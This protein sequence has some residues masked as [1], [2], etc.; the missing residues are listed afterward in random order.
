[1]QRA[2]G[3][4][5]EQRVGA[6]GGGAWGAASGRWVPADRGEPAD[7][8]GAVP[9]GERRGE[10]GGDA[11]GAGGTVGVAGGS[12]GGDGGRR[13]GGVGRGVWA[14]EGGRGAR[15]GRSGV[16]DIHVGIYGKAE[17]GDDR[18]PRSGQHDRR[19]QRA[20]WGGE[21]GCSVRAVVVELRP[22]GVRH[23]W[24]AGRRREAGGSG[25]RRGEGPAGVVD[26]DQGRRG[27]GVEQRAGVD[28]NAVGV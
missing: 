14:G 21:R 16:R 6:G 17:G 11:G 22:I 8:E 12:S 1:G 10:G 18:P 26:G 27:D 13:G 4:G 5:D 23:L 25:S 9:A 15:A 7:R 24:D 3:G 19:N 2:G 28:G 20:D